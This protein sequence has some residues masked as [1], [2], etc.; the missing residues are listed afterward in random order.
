MTKQPSYRPDI[1]GLRAVAVLLVV[2]FHAFPSLMA[3]GYVGVDIFFVISGFLI[4]GLLLADLKRKEFSFANFYGRRIRRIFPALLPVLVVSFAAGWV[5]LLP[6]DF[7]SLGLNIFGGAAFSSNLVLLRETSY[8]GLAAAQKPLLHLWSLGIEE[9]F[10]IVWPVLLLLAFSRRLSIA[11]LAV[12]LLVVSFV[13][14]VRVIGSAADFFLPFTR[15]WELMIGGVMAAVASRNNGIEPDRVS[16]Q[17]GFAQEILPG[18]VATVVAR[19][20]VRAL[21]G[22]GLV[23]VA[24][25]AG[26]TNTGAFPGWWALLPTLGAAFIISA[27]GAWLN[28]NILSHATVV[29][30]GLI[31]YPLYLWHWPLL[32]FANIVAPQSSWRVRIAVIAAAA[33]LAWLTYRW[34]EQPIRTGNRRPLKIALLCTAMALIG[35]AG[36]AV[37]QLDGIPSRIPAPIRDVT[38][39]HADPEFERTMWRLGTCFFEPGQS[40]FTP[41]C[42][43]RG[44]RPLVFLWGDSMAASLYPGLK[45]LQRSVSFGLAQYTMAGCPPSFRVRELPDCGANNDAVLAVLAEARPDVVLL[46]SI[47]AYANVLP[48]LKDLIEK[49]RLLKIPRIVVMGPPASWSDGLPN[50]AFRYYMVHNYLR[51][52]ARQ[53]IP[54]RSNFGVDETQYAYQQRFRDEVESWGV[55]YISA[56]DALCKDD[57][58]VTRLGDSAADLIAFDNAH[59]TLAGSTYLAQAI[60]P[61]LFPDR[62]DRSAVPAPD[63]VDRSRVCG[64]PG[65]QTTKAH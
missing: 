47:W 4:T 61:C 38:A 53:M 52:P 39:I 44:V 10:Y 33:A 37:F 55:E 46:H 60:A 11:I 26:R 43:Q 20:D 54:A 8:F 13:W 59:L 29:L 65:G 56:W 62:A 34:I 51:D 17:I 32:S 21:L 22:L 23:I 50:A 57:E 2:G 14:N 7:T 1:D 12:A 9:Q 28:R 19:P 64:P 18:G 16:N 35:C 6:W 5:V 41:D 40:R 42:L 36:L 63:G 45:Q 30:I 49:L 3:G 24:V 25:I 27:E 31:I 15:A 58:C 48:G